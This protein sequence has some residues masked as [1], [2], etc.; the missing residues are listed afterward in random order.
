MQIKSNQEPINTGI[1][2][3]SQDQYS[4]EEKTIIHK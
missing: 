4:D 2:G 3:R 1:P